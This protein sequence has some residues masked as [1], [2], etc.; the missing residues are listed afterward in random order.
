MYD[1]RFNKLMKQVKDIV[2]VVIEDYDIVCIQAGKGM[3]SQDN[4]VELYFMKDVNVNTGQDTFK[5]MGCSSIK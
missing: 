2:K 5:L 4:E 1:E 3:F